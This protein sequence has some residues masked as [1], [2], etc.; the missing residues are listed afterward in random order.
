[1]AYNV[2]GGT[3]NLTLSLLCVIFFSGC[4]LW[5]T[6]S[7]LLA[8]MLRIHVSGIAFNVHKLGVGSDCGSSVALTQRS[9]V[10]LIS[11]IVRCFICFVL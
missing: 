5:S 11:H 10:V 4:I 9:S 2:F 3:L 1:M 6:H 7:K 8:A